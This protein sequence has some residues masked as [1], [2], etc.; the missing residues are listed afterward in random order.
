MNF[1]VDHVRRE[2]RASRA[3]HHAAAGL[4]RELIGRLFGSGAPAET[5]RAVADLVIG[6]L[7]RRSFLRVGGIT[8]ATSAVLAACGNDDSSSGS[9]GTTDED[10]SDDERPAIE[11]VTILRTASSIEALAFDVYQ[12]AIDSGLLT[13]PSVAEAAKL[14]QAQHKE[15]GDLFQ[16]ATK[17]AGGEPYAAPNAALLQQLQPALAAVRDEAGIVRLAYDIENVAAATYFSTAGVFRD[18]TL[19]RIAMSVGGVEARHAA[20]LATV[21]G[22]PAVPRSF[23]TADGAVPAGT[24]V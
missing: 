6:G 4:W 3:E 24:G 18:A 21:V 9:A 13:T 7:D 1:S 23:H 5:R 11:D 17:E 2:L 22:V 19:N 15:H 12:R 14:F 20:V 16:G 8:I 10:E